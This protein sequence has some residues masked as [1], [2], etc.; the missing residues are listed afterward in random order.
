MS[1]TSRQ[2]YSGSALESAAFALDETGKFATHEQSLEAAQRA[3]DRAHHRPV[4]SLDASARIGDVLD[5]VREWTIVRRGIV[6]GRG[7][8]ADGYR[9]ALADLDIWLREFEARP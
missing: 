4:L 2:P 5:R 3:L 6:T 1:T 7:E 9:L 8:H